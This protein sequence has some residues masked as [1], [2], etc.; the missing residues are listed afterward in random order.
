[1]R[2]ILIDTYTIVL[3]VLLSYIVYILKAQNKK[4]DANSK[5]TMILL[6]IKLIEYHDKYCTLGFI[7]SYVYDNFCNMYE[8]YKALGGNEMV[9]KMKHEV[10]GL[11]TRNNK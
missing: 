10:D 7:P 6:Q 4:R 9:T 2:Q 1:M 8:A 5:G 3:P 11:E